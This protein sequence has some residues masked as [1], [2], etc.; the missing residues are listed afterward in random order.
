MGYGDWKQIDA[1]DQKR[2]EELNKWSGLVSHVIITLV[3]IL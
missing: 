2:G 1:G 3:Y